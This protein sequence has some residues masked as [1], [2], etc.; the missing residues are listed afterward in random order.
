MIINDI[1]W[2]LLGAI[3]GLAIQHLY[4]RLSRRDVAA[5][6][7]ADRLDWANVHYKVLLV[8]MLDQGRIPMY[9]R[10][11]WSGR[12]KQGRQITEVHSPT[13]NVY[14]ALAGDRQLAI[15]VLG[16]DCTDRQRD[17]ILTERG[18]ECARYLR[19]H[20]VRSASLRIDLQDGDQYYAHYGFPPKR[21]VHLM[22]GTPIQPGPS[23]PTQDL[24][25]V[26]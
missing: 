4:Y 22:I 6:R 12:L 24:S 13:C 9:S 14:L 11:S 25:Q 10:L 2:Y 15:T 23:S 20:E 1:V 7:I 21:N 8:A 17:I 3:S 26:G 19:K 16:A 5:E 18:T